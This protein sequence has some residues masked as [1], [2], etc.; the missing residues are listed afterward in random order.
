MGNLFNQTKR[1]EVFVIMSFDEL[2][3]LRWERVIESRIRD[4]LKLAN[5]ATLKKRKDAKRTKINAK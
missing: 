1:D 5:K 2:F 4:L 3:R